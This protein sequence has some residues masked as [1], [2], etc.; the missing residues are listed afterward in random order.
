MGNSRDLIEGENIYLRQIRVIDVNRNYCNWL[1]DP[2]VTQYMESRFEKWTIKKVKDYVSK[3][4]SNPDY[5]FLA[6]Y[7]QKM[8]TNTSVISR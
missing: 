2:E 7:F 1:N 4:K 3:I 8:V 5:V 6:I